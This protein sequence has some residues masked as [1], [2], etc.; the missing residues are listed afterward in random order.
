MSCACQPFSDDL[1]GSPPT[2]LSL[3][4]LEDGDES[5]AHVHAM[6]TRTHGMITHMGCH[7]RAMISHISC[8]RMCNDHWHFS[9]VGDE[10][11]ATSSPGP[12]IVWSACVQRSRARCKPCACIS[13]PAWNTLLSDDPL[14]ATGI[15]TR[16]HAMSATVQ[17]VEG[18]DKDEQPSRLS[19]SLCTA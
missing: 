17:G 19:C 6:P 16:E 1:L 5:A 18:G 11:T 12:L 7:V 13:M 2:P 15:N 14:G 9:L 4:V 10:G 3:V 8:P